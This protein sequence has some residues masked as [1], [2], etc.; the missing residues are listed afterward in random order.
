[1]KKITE[2]Y[3]DFLLDKYLFLDEQHSKWKSK[4]ASGELTNKKG[5]IDKIKNAGLV[6]PES[7]FR[8]SIEKGSKNMIAKTSKNSIGSSLSTSKLM[9]ISGPVTAAGTIM[10][11]KGDPKIFRLLM[12]LKGM[13]LSKD[14]WKKIRFLV[15]RH[16]VDELRILAKRIQDAQKSNNPVHPHSLTFK[17]DNKVVGQHMSPEVLQK[18]KKL[19]TTYNTLYPNKGSEK[20]IKYRNKTGEYGDKVQKAN[21]KKILKSMKPHEIQYQKYMD[22]A[23]ESAREAIMKKNLP[24]KERAKKLLD[25]MKKAKVAAKAK[26]A[27]S[28]AVK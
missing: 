18:E 3:I 28:Y 15:K 24:F 19:M 10:M 5:S 8:K 7:N 12:T 14:D 22:D 26:K 1:M 16:E 20:W 23:V 9:N 25:L 4:V 17:K 2:E 6:K 27:I 21:S 11:P 13:H